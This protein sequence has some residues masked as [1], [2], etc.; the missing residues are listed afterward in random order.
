MSY[1]GSVLVDEET[2]GFLGNAH[3]ELVLLRL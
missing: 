3:V 2:C 1:Y